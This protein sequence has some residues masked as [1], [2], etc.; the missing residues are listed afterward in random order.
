MTDLMHLV[1]DFYSGIGV[2]I[3]IGVAWMI[4]STVKNTV[5]IEHLKERFDHLENNIDKR[6]EQIDK[7]FEQIDKRFERLEDKLDQV[8]LGLVNMGINSAREKKIKHPPAA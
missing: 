4:R 6:F 3:L 8:L 5:A 7:R 1:S 2:S